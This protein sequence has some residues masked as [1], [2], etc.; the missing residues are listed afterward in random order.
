MIYSFSSFAH[1][2]SHE[3]WRTPLHT[4]YSKCRTYI[5][6]ITQVHQSMSITSKKSKS[7]CSSWKAEASS[8]PPSTLQPWPFSSDWF[9]AGKRS[10]PRW[11]LADQH[12]RISYPLQW[13]TAWKHLGNRSP[14][15][16]RMISWNFI[17]FIHPS[18]CWMWVPRREKVKLPAQSGSPG[19]AYDQGMP[20]TWPTVVWTGC[21]SSI[22]TQWAPCITCFVVSG[23]AEWINFTASY[24]SPWVI[25]FTSI[26]KIQ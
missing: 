16:E 26:V 14:N 24:G 7:S 1:K 23:E 15:W 20:N 8:R 9:L 4:T 17:C 11:L 10:Y 22:H 2:G 19:C 21:C 25:T 3:E 18:W 6:G 13:S 5:C 12:H